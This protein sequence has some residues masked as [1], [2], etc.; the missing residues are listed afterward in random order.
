[1][2]LMS[3]FVCRSC[4]IRPS[5]SMS[6]I[7]AQSLEDWRN[8][9]LWEQDYKSMLLIHTATTLFSVQI[10]YISIGSS[11]TSY[12][13]YFLTSRCQKSLNDYL[14]SK[15]RIFPRFFFIST[16][17][18]LSILGSSECS[19]VQ[20]HMIKVRGLRVYIYYYKYIFLGLVCLRRLL[21]RL[22]SN[23]CF[24]QLA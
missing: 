10:L 13:A 17:E 4:Q 11:L 22:L 12:F 8:S 19:C 1:M 9:S 24:S 6:S 15:R 2:S 7:A 18:L 21:S 5:A 23:Y 16:D 3:G 14:D 20:E